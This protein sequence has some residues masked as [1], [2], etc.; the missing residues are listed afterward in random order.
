M[1]FSWF[2]TSII[3][4]FSFFIIKWC[5]AK[6]NTFFLFIFTLIF[7]FIWII[8]WTFRRTIMKF[9]CVIIFN[10]II[11]TSTIFY[12]KFFV[13]SIIKNK[14]IIIAN[15]FSKIFKTSCFV[16]FKIF[17][18]IIFA[19]VCAF[20]IFY[21]LKFQSIAIIYTFFYFIIIIISISFKIIIFWANYI[22]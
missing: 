18:Y 11:S 6:C 3:T 9:L 17:Y 5:C 14:T 7:H 15:A 20:F 22:F 1:I 21:V 13:I 12:T 19:V 8:T 2:I 16:T 10:C 4:S